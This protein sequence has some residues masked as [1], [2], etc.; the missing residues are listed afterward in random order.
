M[1]P[2]YSVVTEHPF[3]HLMV[4]F[5]VHFVQSA[6]STSKEACSTSKEKSKAVVRDKWT[7]NY[8]DIMSPKVNKV[9]LKEKDHNSWLEFK[10]LDEGRVCTI[11][12]LVSLCIHMFHA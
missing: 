3:Y 6:C 5:F 7:Q 1:R 8:I 12:F 11:Y 10:K 4:F 9:P 2:I